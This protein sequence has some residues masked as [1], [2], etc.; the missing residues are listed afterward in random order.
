MSTLLIP[1]PHMLASPLVSPLPPWLNVDRYFLDQFSLAAVSVT[2][3]EAAVQIFSDMTNSKFLT[4]TAI[5]TDGLQIKTPKPSTS[6]ALFISSK[7]VL[8]SWKLHPE[9]EVMESELFVIREAMHWSQNNLTTE[10]IFIF[11]DS[12]AS[13]HFI[14]NR[15][16]SC[17]LSLIFI[18]Q[19]KIMSLTSSRELYIQYIPGHKEIS[20]NETAHCAAR[21]AHSLRYCT[22]TIM[23]RKELVRLSHER[24]Q[25]SWNQSWL[26]NVNNSG[27]SHFFTLIKNRSASVLGPII[28]NVQLRPP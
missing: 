16:P 26:D 2:S 11:T 27:N 22:I 14:K 5:Y 17:Y 15:Q 10:K 7:G 24:V 6:M 9:V 13:I 28:M 8:P 4:H 3:S 18:I 21:D 19:S 12:Q 20:G 25:T 1:V 23:S